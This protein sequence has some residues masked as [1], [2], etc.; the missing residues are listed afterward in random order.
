MGIR[1]FTLFCLGC[2]ITIV[3]TTRVT[4][5][6]FTEVSASA[7]SGFNVDARSAS[8]AD[9]DEDGDLDLFFQGASGAQQ[10]F[11]N[12]LIGSGSL[13]FTNIALPSGLGP[14]WSA[15]WGDYDGDGDVDVFVGQSNIGTSGD[16]LR[17]DGTGAFTNVSVATGLNDPGFHQNVAWCDIDNDL[18]LDLI[19]GMEGP[20]PHEIY[21]QGAGTLFTPVGAAVGFQAPFG[22]KA[23]GMAIGD[24]DGDGDRDI[25]LSTCRGDNNIRNNFYEN[26][27]IDTGTLGFVDIADANGTQFFQN[28]YHAEFA[29]FDDDGDLDL[30][31]VGAD[32]QLTKIFRNDGGNQFTDVDTITGTA[33]LDN[34]GGDYDGGRAIDYDHDGDLDLFFHDH[35]PSN[36]K[37][38]ARR[39]YRNDGNWVFT[40]VTVA[41]GIDAVCEGAYDSAWGDIDLD[42]DMDLIAPTDSGDVERIFLN[43]ASANGSHWLQIRLVGPV[44]NTTGIGAALYATT[45]LGL[46]AE[47]TIRRD[48]NPNAGTFNQS[49]LPVHFG[50]GASAS[51]DKLRI[52]WPDGTVQHLCNVPTDQYLTVHYP[53]PGD[54]N[55]DGI[56]DYADIAVFTDCIGGPGQPVSP[57][58]PACVD[59]CDILDADADNDIDLADFMALSVVLGN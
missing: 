36:G 35:R 21:L 46:P 15:C 39:L 34:L 58:S 9:I 27:L 12:N 24:S 25:Y 13:T 33:L 49:D 57:A 42:G 56:S 47:R 14:S 7:L 23:Y 53:E 6:T 40:D 22:T 55:G 18:D 17:N 59:T 20:E 32:G 16:L 37:D 30:F 51:A 5:A 52:E 8:L 38:Q 50:F 48:A 2:A 43:D 10:L 11:R 41:A 4:A 28:S 26:R 1:G 3:G 31:M 29:D 45:N 19:L 54:F 44:E